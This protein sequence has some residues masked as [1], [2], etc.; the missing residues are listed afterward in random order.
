L[1]LRITHRNIQRIYDAIMPINVIVPDF[2]L[3]S[4]L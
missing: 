1:S 3:E 2:A 4:S